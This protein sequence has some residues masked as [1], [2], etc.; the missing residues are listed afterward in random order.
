MRGYARV[1]G[2]IT[3]VN[4]FTH[5]QHNK[6]ADTEMIGNG[7]EKM[8]DYAGYYFNQA[9]AVALANKALYARRWELRGD[10]AE[11]L[12][13]AWEGQAQLADLFRR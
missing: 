7:G 4:N 10:D 12:A 5:K 2:W 1:G 3:P 9:E 13:K 11:A 6:Q 8:K